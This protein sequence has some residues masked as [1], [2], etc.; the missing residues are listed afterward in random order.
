MTGNLLANV[1]VRR[2]SR[3]AGFFL[4]LSGGIDSCATALTVYSAARLISEAIE[5][6]NKQVLQDVQNVAG[7]SDWEPKGAADICNHILHTC[8]M[9]TTNSS[10]ETRSRSGQLAKAIGGYHLDIDIDTIINSF[11]TL[12]SAVLSWKLRYKTQ[13][14][15]AQ[16]S[17]A[18][19][20]I[21]SRSRM[22]LAYLF[23]STLTLIRKRP[24]GGSLLVLGSANVDEALR[25]YYTKYDNSSGDINPIGGI[26]K[27]DLRSFIRFAK[28]EWDLP[29]LEEFITATPT[30]ELEPISDTYVQSDEVDMGV[31]YEELG[32]FGRLRKVNK[33]GPYA[34]W[35]RLCSNEWSQRDPRAVFEKV[36]FLWT[37]FGINR[38]KQE[39]LTPSLHAE[40]YSPGELLFEKKCINT[41]VM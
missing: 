22:V 10:K 29:L 4:P 2:R 1:Y 31:T 8:F 39:I 11:T 19:Q 41:N 34:M 16:E 37:Q 25:G 33:L 28:D 3:Q 13:G 35:C 6:G 38:H 12:F 20:N 7:D 36:R 24:G 26:S 21:Q 18:L 27:T 15:S 9:G 32:I 40:E 5:S 23:A 14:G 30:A 17:L